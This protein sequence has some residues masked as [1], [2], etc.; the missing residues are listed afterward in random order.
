MK[1][2]LATASGTQ[3][4]PKTT[5]M[6]FQS[7]FRRR[8]N[9]LKGS[10]FLFLLFNAAILFA[11]EDPPLVLH[12]DE[13][14]QKWAAEALPVGNG[15]LGAMVFGGVK[16][17]RL[18]LNEES[19]WAGPPVPEIS[20]EFK[21]AFQ[22][23]RKLWFEGKCTEAQALVQEHM[24][25]RI[26]P[27]SYQT[28]GDLKIAMHDDSNAPVP[29]DYRRELDLD[30]AVATTVFTLDG[31]QHRRQVFASSPADVLVVHWTADA[32]GAIDALV[33]LE[34]SADARVEALDDS[35]LAMHGQAGHGGKQLGVHFYSLLRATAQ[36]GTVKA[37]PEGSLDIRGADSLTLILD[38]RTDYNRKNPAEPLKVDLRKSVAKSVA[39]AAGRELRSMLD[40]HIADHQRLFRRCQLDL[41]GWDAA[42][43]PTDERMA[44][45]KQSYAEGTIPP[46]D[47]PALFALYFQ[48]GRYLLISSSRPDDL[49]AN[50][51]GIWNDRIEAPWNA[52][53]HIN[54][55]VQMN[56]WPAEVTNLSECHEPFFNFIE[57][58]VPAG[59]K[60]AHDAY[61]ARGF[62]AHHTTDAW[63]HTAPFGKVQYGMWPHGAGWSTQHFMEHYRFTQDEAFLRQRAWPILR[64]AAAFY[65]D[66]LEEDPATGKLVCGLDTSPENR[67]RIPGSKDVLQISMGASMSQQIVWDVFTNALEAARILDVDD[68]LV[69]E[70]QRA[71]ER[72]AETQI[73]EDGRLMEWARPFEEPSPGHRHISHLFAIHPGRQ[74]TVQSNPEMVDA[75]RKSIDYRLE[76]GGGHTGWSRAWIVNFRARFRQPD[77][78]WYNL[79]ALLAKSTTPNL[80]DTHPPFQIDG[81]F[82]GTA[83]IAEMLLQ[84]HVGDSQRGYLIELLP[85]LPS[86]WPSGSVRGLRA[87]GGFT[88]DMRWAEGKLTEYRLTHPNKAEARVSTG[89]QSVRVLADGTWRKP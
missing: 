12:Y 11:A 1:T 62:V 14:A 7:P 26:S 65:L 73:G 34:R 23:A 72:L 27:R 81:N 59:R 61:G 85:A 41:G 32:P 69:A 37:T 60:M 17:E 46:C 16:T 35:T 64:E 67:F 80:F 3:S 74:Y 33:S 5:G 49:P 6:P 44:R 40:E 51:Q 4:S 9:A 10:L 8:M 38:A 39:A 2:R 83:G 13:P 76:H 82:G 89:D 70:I 43:Q 87:R 25:E 78:A 86:C 58:L 55:N 56:Y 48:F 45:I 77:E 21:G 50:L 30:R 66:Y 29:E 18:Q 19:I 28:L 52:D 31:V 20:A 42:A 24:P 57:S 79:H 47:D 22:Q 88:V 53:Y 54:I 68:P 63:L 75:A 71:R 84:S 15:R 36:G